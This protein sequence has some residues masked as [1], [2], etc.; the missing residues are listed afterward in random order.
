MLRVASSARVEVQLKAV[1]G[2]CKRCRRCTLLPGGLSPSVHGAGYVVATGVSVGR[3]RSSGL[4]KGI[5]K[6][7]VALAE[8]IHPEPVK[9]D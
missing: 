7:L 3:L 1:R 2:T 4:A 9:M 8:A 6:Q 5:W